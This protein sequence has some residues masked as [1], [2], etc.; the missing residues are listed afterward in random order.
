MGGLASKLVFKRGKDKYN[1]SHYRSL[2]DIPATDI[3]GNQIQQL[4][5]IL[6]GK[7]CIL[8]TNLYKEYRDQGFEILAFPCN[9][10]MN[11]EPGTPEEIKKFI[12]ELYGGEWPIFAKSDVNGVNSNE[13]F[14]F[15]RMNS[16]LHDHH[17]KEVKEIPWN[18]AKFLVDQH[19]NVVSYHNPRVEPLAMQKEI[20]AMLYKGC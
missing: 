6:Q 9:Q 15:L 4:G 10:F 17:K 13:V 8:V 19:G 7:R 1:D 12:K 14:K 16:E 11:Q 20:E 18:F 2:L 5:D 3:D